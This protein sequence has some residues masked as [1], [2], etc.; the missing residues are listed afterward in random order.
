MR[1]W[2]SMFPP[3]DKRQLTKASG[4]TR[5]VTLG[6]AFCRLILAVNGKLH[7]S[8]QTVSAKPAASV[9]TRVIWKNLSF[10]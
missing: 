3:R 8:I 10:L 9:T 2:K 4:L 5:L 7:V 1:L 6:V